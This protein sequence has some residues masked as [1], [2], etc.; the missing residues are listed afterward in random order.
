M[1]ILNIIILLIVI[2]I[3]GVCTDL[4][5]INVNF[6]N[7]KVFLISVLGILYTYWTSYW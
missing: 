7:L 4:I 1:T 3:V 6:E 5:N 2:I